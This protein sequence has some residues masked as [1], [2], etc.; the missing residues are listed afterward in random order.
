MTTGGNSW[1]VLAKSNTFNQLPVEPA[2]AGSPWSSWSCEYK[3]KNLSLV[4]PNCHP[5]T[6]VPVGPN[7]T[8]GRWG[9]KVHTSFLGIVMSRNVFGHQEDCYS[10]GGDIPVQ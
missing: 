6:N 1:W 10:D 9:G 4:L 5:L 3:A 2:K 7:L 8:G